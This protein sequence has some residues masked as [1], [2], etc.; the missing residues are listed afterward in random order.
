MIMI[1]LVRATEPGRAQNVNL[2]CLYSAELWS[3]R[4]DI[5]RSLYSEVSWKGSAMRV[6]LL[7]AL[8]EDALRCFVEESI[9]LGMQI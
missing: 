9:C 6:R 4:C 7:F 5:W 8:C 2:R 1:P 3:M